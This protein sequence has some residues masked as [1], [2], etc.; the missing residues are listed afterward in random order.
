[1]PALHDFATWEP[2]LRSIRTANADEIAGGGLHV[3]GHVQRHGGFGA[4]AHL[5]D[6][7]ALFQ[8]VTDMG[9]AFDQAAVDRVAF[10]VSFAPD[11]RTVL[12]I[13]GSNPAVTSGIGSPMGALLLVDGAVPE[14][15][16]RLPERFPD[17]APDASADADL[18]ERTLRERLPEA[19]GASEEELS[20]AEARLGVA[21][22]EEVRALYRVVGGEPPLHGDLDLDALGREATA[23]GFE[24]FPLK[25]VYVAYAASRHFLWQHGAMEVAATVPGAAVQD[26]PGSPG[27]IV[28]GDT[29]GGDR[30]AVDLTPG[31]G[32][33]TGQLIVISHE[34]SVGADHVA[35]SLTD[36]VVHHVQRGAGR[37]RGDQPYVAHVNHASVTSIEAAA[38]P[39]LQVLSLGVWDGEPFSLA[40][41]TGLP[42]LRTLAAYPGTLADPLEIAGLTGLEYLELSSTD[43]RVLLDADAVPRTLLAAGVEERGRPDPR[44]TVEV[45]NALLA[46]WGREPIGGKVV[47]GHLGRSE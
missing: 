18:L 30:I 32:G 36:W 25:E 40:A 7:A 14:P 3:S 45:A 24:L 11:G 13:W 34:E 29:G 4:N 33:H 20:R 15:W 17:V 1:M 43:W 8:V 26:L 46:L 22:P 16:R 35:P 38:H 42:R 41:V 2:F 39:E 10:S 5:G 47:E 37:R 9:E 31:P 44:G 28:V 19:V 12:R 27:W 23:V 6:M 21:L